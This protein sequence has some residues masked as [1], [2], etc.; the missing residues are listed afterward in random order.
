[1]SITKASTASS[2]TERRAS[3]LVLAAMCLGVLL[4]QLDS[5][6]VNL[7]LKHIGAELHS[8]VSGLQWVLDAYNLTYA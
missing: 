5:M 3:S 8:G 2:W 4:A 6:V 7:A 1:M